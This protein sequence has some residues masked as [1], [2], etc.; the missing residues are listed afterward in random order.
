MNPNNPVITTIGLVVHP[1]GTVVET[2]FL[3]HMSR[4]G[5]LGGQKTITESGSLNYRKMAAE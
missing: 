1:T 5:L 2:G 4:S 3:K